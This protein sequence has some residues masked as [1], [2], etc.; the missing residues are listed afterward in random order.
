MAGAGLIPASED[1]L[2][3]TMALIIRGG[4]NDKA[5][6]DAPKVVSKLLGDG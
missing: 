6:W 4:D 3:I 5:T 2:G 1:G